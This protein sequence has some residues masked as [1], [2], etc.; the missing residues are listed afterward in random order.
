M[1]SSVVNEL[2]RR[3]EVAITHAREVQSRAK[4]LQRD[5]RALAAMFNERKIEDWEDASNELPPPLEHPPGSDRRSRS[6][7]SAGR[8]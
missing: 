4:E 8:S 6:N 7:D 3:A 5:W 1:T 2:L